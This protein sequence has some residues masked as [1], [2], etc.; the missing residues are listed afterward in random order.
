VGAAKDQG[1]LGKA[2]AA[3][4]QGPLGKANCRVNG[5]AGY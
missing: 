4:D 2:G 3:K 5:T 1:P